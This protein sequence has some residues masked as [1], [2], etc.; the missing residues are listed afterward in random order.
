MV[1]LL[2]LI[3]LCII[4]FEVPRLVREE[5]WRELAVFS[6]LLAIGFGISLAQAMGLPIP[7]PTK[8]IETI[9]GF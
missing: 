3:F 5:M 6:V 7:N 8:I 4:L 1:I 9:F 2:I